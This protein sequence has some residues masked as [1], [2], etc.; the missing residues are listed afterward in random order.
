MMQKLH[1]VTFK[2]KKE[3]SFSKKGIIYQELNT[4]THTLMHMRVHTKGVVPYQREYIDLNVLA[5]NKWHI[6]TGMFV[7]SDLS[8]KYATHT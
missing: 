8:M 6:T 5:E 3:I 1:K 4:H 2:D 7:K